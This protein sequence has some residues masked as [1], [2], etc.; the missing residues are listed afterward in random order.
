MPAA[1][2]DYRVLGAYSDQ[3]DPLTMTTVFRQSNVNFAPN[4]TPDFIDPDNIQPNPLN[5][6]LAASTF[7]Q[8]LR[9]TNFAK[10]RDIVGA[11]NVRMPLQTKG[12]VASFLKYG[13]K[14]RDKQKGRDRNEST[15]TTSR[16]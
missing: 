3:Y 16:D 5:E 15:Y 14:Y 4:V 12:T 8:Q 2:I 7:N 6:N 13:V 10:D 9:A 1:E 11:L